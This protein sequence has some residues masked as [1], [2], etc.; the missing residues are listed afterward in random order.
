M[1]QMKAMVMKAFLVPVLLSP[2]IVL[3][4]NDIKP[5][6]RACVCEDNDLKCTLY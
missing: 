5:Y 6:Q 1:T 4:N 3:H 2:I